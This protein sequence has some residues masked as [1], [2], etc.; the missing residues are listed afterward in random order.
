MFDNIKSVLKKHNIDRVC[1]ININDCEIIN[2]RILPEWSKS[3]IIFSI[4]YRSTTELSEDGFSEYARIYDYHKFSLNLY[5]TLSQELNADNDY[6]FKGFCDHSPINEKLAA[7][8]C[9]LGFIGRNSLFFDRKYGSF[10]FLGSIITDYDC[11]DE[12]HEIEYCDNCGLCIHACPN[13]AILERGIDR[14]RCL[15][16]ISQKKKKSPEEA[17]L[18]KEHNIVWG[19]DICQNICPHNINAEINPVPYFKETRVRKVDKEFII[20]LSD[21]EFEKYAFSYKGRQI[22]IDNI[23]F[24][25]FKP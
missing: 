1:I 11:P 8:K 16:G 15:S 12:T 22:V 5:A 14:F 9:G 20:S 6:K 4:P 18:L 23:D 3:A 24:N 17:S 13:Q 10:V 21:E 2:Q 19:C 25:G 7:A